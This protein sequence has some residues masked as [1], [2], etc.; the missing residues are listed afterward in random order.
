M[1]KVAVIIP[2]FNESEGLP[3]LLPRLKSALN[4]VPEYYSVSVVLIDDGST[5]NTWE[6]IRSFSTSDDR[7]HGVK[8]LRN[9]GSHSAIRAGLASVEADYYIGISADLQDPPEIIPQLLSEAAKGFNVVWGERKKR[10]DPIF[11]TLWAKLFWKI[12]H[13]YAGPGYPEGGADVFL[14][15]RQVVR[16]LLSMREKN[17]IFYLLIGWSGYHASTV[18]YTR[19][20]RMT[21]E[22]KW[23]FSKRVKTALGAFVSFSY[24]PIQFISL[25]GILFSLFGFLLG[26]FLVFSYFSGNPAPGWTSLAVGMLILSGIQMIML[27]VVAEYLWRVFDQIKDRPDYIIET[28]VGGK[29]KQSGGE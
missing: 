24:T 13:R 17:P 23:S 18:T 14:F 20:A 28:T 5:D 8:L 16:H 4:G 26:L 9:F 21:G 3:L 7:I 15:S 12:I 6:L 19:A 1:K 25:T 11:K 10:R 29:E 27:G 22:T 2:C